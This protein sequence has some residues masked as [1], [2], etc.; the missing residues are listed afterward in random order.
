MPER[1]C[2]LDAASGLERRTLWMLLGINVSMF[3]AEAVAGWWGESAGLLADSL[4]ML[5][6]A[7]VYAIALYAVGQSRTLQASAAMTSGILQSL[8]GVGVFVEVVRRFLYGSEPI[9]FLM[10][11]T[12]A[13]ALAANLTCLALLARHRE[14]GVHMR[15]SWIFSINDAIA[16]L[17][18]IVSGALVLALNSRLPDLLI[19]ATISMVVLHG[20]IQIMR[21]AM[22]A[23]RKR[24][25]N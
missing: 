7:A 19:G 14:G 12:G 22:E 24:D 9:S 5:A 13:V 15:A 25:P 6:D 17:G 4:D 2:E 16:N 1:G 8:L 21:E 3:A 11:A 23:G 10:M 20:G 18:V